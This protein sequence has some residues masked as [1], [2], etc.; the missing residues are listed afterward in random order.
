V[1]VTDPEGNA[2]EI[3]LRR[4]RVTKPVAPDDGGF[5]GFGGTSSQK[6]RARRGGGGADSSILDWL[7][8]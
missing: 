7:F 5:F 4:A 6:R 2:N 1:V 8:R 3:K